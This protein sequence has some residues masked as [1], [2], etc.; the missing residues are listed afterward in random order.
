MAR[1][2]LQSY[3]W[4]PLCGSTFITSSLRCPDEQFDIFLLNKPRNSYTVY[5][6]KRT[7]KACFNLTIQTNSHELYWA[8]RRA[9]HE[10]NSLILVRLMKS[11]TFGPLVLD[12]CGFGRFKTP[13]SQKNCWLV[14]QDLNLQVRGRVWHLLLHLGISVQKSIRCIYIPVNTPLSH[15]P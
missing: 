13:R 8:R 7:D 9:F 6:L 15:F 4:N 11:S 2:S 5:L 10:L 12:V 1:K 3:S 14:S